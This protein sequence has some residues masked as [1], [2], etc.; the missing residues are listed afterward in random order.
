VI[1]GIG[2]DLIDISRIEGTL[3]RFGDRFLARVFTDDE[4]RRCDAKATRAASYAKRFA[5][6]EAVWKALGEGMRV[7]IRWRELEVVNLK[8]GKPSLRLTGQAEERLNDLMPENMSPRVDL[9]LSDEPPMAMAF[10]VISAEPA[11]WSQKRAPDC[12][13]TD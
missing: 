7:G 1:I 5:A 2:S 12:P 10:V 9:S 3:E 6:K 8:S 13:G 11:E 4:R